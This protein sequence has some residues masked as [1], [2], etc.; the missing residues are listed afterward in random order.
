MLHKGTTLKCNYHQLFLHRQV[1]WVHPEIL[2]D[3]F[4]EGCVYKQ[5]NFEA[6]VLVISHVVYYYEKFMTL[7]KLRHSM[8]CY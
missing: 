1:G 8:L 7:R 3:G 5:L 6:K 2:A 4:F